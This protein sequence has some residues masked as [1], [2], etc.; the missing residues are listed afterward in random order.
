MQ[1]KDTGVLIT[2]FFI[3]LIGIGIHIFEPGWIINPSGTGG[4]FVGAGIVLIG[5]GIRSI[6]LKNKG[7]I[8]E[9]ERIFYIAEKASHKTLTILIILQGILMAFLGITAFD[10]QAYPIVSLLFAITVLTYVGFYHWYKRR[11]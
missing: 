11:F 6:R 9:D 4:A 8:V 1:T 5:L 10:I 7:T 2:G 3:S